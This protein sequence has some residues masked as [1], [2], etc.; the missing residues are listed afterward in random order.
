MSRARTDRHSRRSCSNLEIPV[1][2]TALRI[3]LISIAALA[4]LV[5]LL[6]LLRSKTDKSGKSE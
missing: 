3:A 5:L 4:A 2:V 1:N 6:V